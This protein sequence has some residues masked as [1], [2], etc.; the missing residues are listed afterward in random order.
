MQAEELGKLEESVGPGQDRT[1]QGNGVSTNKHSAS[2]LRRVR[3]GAGSVWCRVQ[4]CLPSSRHLS[5]AVY[6]LPGAL[7]RFARGPSEGD[8]LEAPVDGRRPG[9]E[10]LVF[11]S[12]ALLAINPGTSP[13]KAGGSRTVPRAGA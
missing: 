9:S 7:F 4:G 11:I 10:Q 6:L 5:F 8:S 1:P 2:A 13:A 3:W 12:S